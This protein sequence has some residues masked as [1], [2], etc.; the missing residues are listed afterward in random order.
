MQVQTGCMSAKPA[1]FA[2][3]ATLQHMIT[4][5]VITTCHSAQHLLTVK[6]PLIM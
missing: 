1:Y 2:H 5:R 3:P 6:V 4:S